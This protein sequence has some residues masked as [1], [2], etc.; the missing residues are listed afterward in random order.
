MQ[1]PHPR[2][3]PTLVLLGLN[4]S[5]ALWGLWFPEV[6]REPLVSADGWNRATLLAVDLV[7]LVAFA[8]MAVLMFWRHRGPRWNALWLGGWFFSAYAHSFQV[9]TTD[10]NAMYPLHLTGFVIS[11]WGSVLAVK[12]LE[13][14]LCAPATARSKGVGVWMLLVASCLVIVWSA[15]WKTQLAS[16]FADA[17]QN[18]LIRSIAGLDLVLVLPAFVWVGVGLWRGGF[19]N[20]P[21]PTALNLAFGIYMAAL[22]VAC[23][24]QR[25][26]GIPTAMGELPQWTLLAA[27]SLGGA[28]LGLPGKG[29]LGVLSARTAPNS[30][31][32]ER[33]R[34]SE[35]PEVI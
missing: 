21:L 14:S 16:G 33:P 25:A 12:R 23:L 11:V 18:D 3:F 32:Q 8:A 20:S 35:N 9:F 10:L 29:A 27:G 1:T 17:H 22:A 34:P 26:A 28:A 2:S 30:V 15:S 24:T 4:L 7:S 13:A 6:Y 19:Q 5:S 31:L